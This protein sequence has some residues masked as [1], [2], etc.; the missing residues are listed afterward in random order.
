MNAQD[1]PAFVRL[2][3]L[4][5]RIASKWRVRITA[6]VEI[7]NQFKFLHRLIVFIMSG[8]KAPSSAARTT[9]PIVI[10]IQTFR[11]SIIQARSVARPNQ[12]LAPVSSLMVRSHAIRDARKTHGLTM[13][14]K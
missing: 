9:P 8:S 7:V 10:I 11:G 5:F 13:V 2:G 3:L 4:K 14:K 12:H 6:A 1:I